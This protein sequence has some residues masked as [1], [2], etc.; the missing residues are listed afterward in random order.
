MYDVVSRTKSIIQYDMIIDHRA[1][2]SRVGR[3]VGWGRGR[4]DRG[5]GRGGVG[6]E[7]G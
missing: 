5:K 1:T 7:E 4:V 6:W 3:G 2:R